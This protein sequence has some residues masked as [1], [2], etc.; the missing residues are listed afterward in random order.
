MTTPAAVFCNSRTKVCP[1]GQVSSH[2]PGGTRAWCRCLQHPSIEIS[3]RDSSGQDA[4]VL[5]F[6]FSCVTTV[7]TC[8]ESSNNLHEI[9]EAH[10]EDAMPQLSQGFRHFESRSDSSRHIPTTLPKIGLSPD[11]KPAETIISHPLFDHNVECGPRLNWLA[12]LQR[13]ISTNTP[14]T[15]PFQT[16]AIAI[17]VLV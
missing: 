14:S 3:G 9:Y 16:K 7:G 5:L 6:L 11:S 13:A 15:C 8:I 17:H 4:W 10:H 2:F 1:I 12:A